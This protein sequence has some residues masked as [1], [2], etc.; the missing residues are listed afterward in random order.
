MDKLAFAKALLIHLVLVGVVL[1]SF[2]S[3]ESVVKPKPVP[4]HIM[5]VVVE[6]PKPKPKVK[7][8]AIVKKKTVKKKVKKKPKPKAKPKKKVKPKVKAKPKVKPKPKPKPEPKAE[9]P[10]F[11]DLLASEAKKIKKSEPKPLPKVPVIDKAA[12][13]KAKARAKYIASEIDTYSALISQTV[14]RYWNRPPSARNGMQV[15]L[16]I[17]L[18][19]GGELNSVSISRSSGNAAFDRAAVNAV[20]R[21]GDF[22]V[23]ADSEIFDKHFREFS[24][25]FNPEDLKY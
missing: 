2:H 12:E 22:T 16:K 9:E 3:S 5:A 25:L 8:K 18:L 24:M 7:K 23:P 15:K 1:F 21:A 10:S 6:K 19:P 14:R 11:E 4:Q 17:R 13:Q 20:E